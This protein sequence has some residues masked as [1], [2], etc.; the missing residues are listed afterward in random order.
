MT[1]DEIATI[2]SDPDAFRRQAFDVLREVAHR[3]AS[4]EAAHD[5]QARQDARQLVIRC[6]ERRAEMGASKPVHDALLAR[7]GLYPYLD[8]PEKLSLGDRLEYEAHRP[9][10]SP[11][12]EFVFHAMQAQVY[13]RLMDGDTVILTAPTS[14]GKTLIVDA[15]VVSGKYDNMVIVVPTIALIDEVRRRMSRL[16][17]QYGL[18]FNVI[19][20][21]GQSQG[22]RNIFVFTQERV[23]Q[24]DDFPALG[25]VVIDEMYKLSLS[26][27]SDRGPL[28]NQALY[29]LRKLT[30]Q[31]YLLGPNVGNISNLPADFEHRFIPSGDST[32]AVDVITV[33]RTDDE[34]DDLVRVCT[35][36]SEPTLI[37]VKSPARANEVARWL[38]EAGLQANGL[39]D[40]SNWLADNYHP[41]WILAASLRAGIGVHHGRLSRAVAHYIVSAFNQ[42][43]LRF[44]VCTST[45]IEG[46]NTT[47]KN[48]VI[49]DNT[50]KRRKYDLFTFRN[51]QGRSGRMFKHFI[52]RVYLFNPEPNDALPDID[53]PILS[54]PDDTPVGLLL[55]MDEKDL[56][57]KSRGRVQPYLDQDMLPVDVLRENADVNLDAQ[58]GLAE[59]LSDDVH[60]QSERLA[61]TD[62]P[63]YEE[64]KAVSELVFE[65]FA[66]TARGWGAL[67]APQ[68]TLLVW[69]SY[70]KESAQDLIAGQISFAAT[71]EKGIDQVVLDVL[72]FQRSGLTFGFPK[73]LRV[74]DGIQRAV[75]RRAGVPFGDYSRFAAAAEG[76]FLPPPL[77]ALDEYG[78][79][80]ELSRKLG[81]HLLPRGGDDSLDAVLARLRDLSDGLAGLGSF[82]RELLH[83]AKRDL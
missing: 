36:L 56:T 30:R 46:V 50:I 62:F 4:A 74:V 78:L 38:V 19:T 26:Q 11:R 44:L 52:G 61:W 6:L 83:E 82:E 8:D 5:E 25:I 45:L 22:S 81:A 40:A 1:S 67:S 42:E 73:Y 35:D 24:E 15:L 31:L 47:A 7:V 76:G 68:L 41:E 14:F 33:D 51:I 79:P 9:L 28:L 58:L 21:P 75:F 13:A 64:L 77:A 48:I 10:V 34:R 39:P 53:I 71:K 66:K 3:H 63:K 70:Q 54:Q 20:H 55:T 12:D 27:D 2:L 72:T 32:V 65:F 18:L 80:L 69:K 37:F 16:N 59:K 29:K 60:R 23:L 17:E 49:F 43:K 57:T